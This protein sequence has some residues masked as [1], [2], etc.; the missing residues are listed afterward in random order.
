VILSYRFRRESKPPVDGASALGKQ[1]FQEIQNDRA[2]HGKANDHHYRHAQLTAGV[3]LG[4]PA[5]DATQ[6]SPM[7]FA[8][9]QFAASRSVAKNAH[10]LT[11][12][13]QSETRR[14]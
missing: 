12:S 10:S 14:K 4:R 6:I 13:N 1:V 7:E 8:A 11:R 2:K 5:I 3:F 9:A